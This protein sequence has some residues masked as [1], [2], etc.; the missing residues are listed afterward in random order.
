MWG[1]VLICNNDA[2]GEI[3]KEWDEVGQREPIFGAHGRWSKIDIFFCYKWI[4]VSRWFSFFW[5]QIS[6]NTDFS[7][8]LTLDI[9]ES[10]LTPWKTA[11]FQVCPP[12]GGT[13]GQ[14]PP[15]QQTCIGLPLWTRLQGRH[16]NSKGEKNRYTADL[17]APTDWGE[18]KLRRR[19]WKCK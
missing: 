13:I 5:V 11:F 2:E 14:G 12:K 16:W 7:W 8:A 19:S 18:D 1:Y 4:N 15:I 17:I 10:G 9:L 3:L 6:L